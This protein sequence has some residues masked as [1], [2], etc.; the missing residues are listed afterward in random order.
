MVDR[1]RVKISDPLAIYSGCYIR[2][3]INIYGR[4]SKTRR[5][6]GSVTMH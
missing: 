3:S 5:L 6:R 4:M 1:K 2:A